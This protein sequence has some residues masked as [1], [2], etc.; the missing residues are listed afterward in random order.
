MHG[1]FCHDRRSAASLRTGGAVLIAA[2]AVLAAVAAWSTRPSTAADRRPRDVN[3]IA[4]MQDA[5]GGGGFPYFTVAASTGAIDERD[6][7]IYN[8]RGSLLT[9]ANNAPDRARLNARYNVSAVESL[10]APYNFLSMV[11]RFRDN[12]D[13]ARV[14]VKLKEYDF[15]TGQTVTRL[16]FDSNDFGPD[17][18]FQREFVTLNNPEWVFNFVEKAY[19]LDVVLRKSGSNG[20]PQLGAIQIATF[21]I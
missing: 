11:V 8:A 6:L 13:D 9:I 19:F 5:D 21:S 10:V 3:P 4:L 15:F 12:G 2:I 16:V 7:D 18:G 17:G 14:L 1:Q 20:R